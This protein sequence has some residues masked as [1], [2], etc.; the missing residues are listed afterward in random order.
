MFEG[1]KALA[2]L[3]AIREQPLLNE[4]ECGR[5]VDDLFALRARWVQRAA[6]L[7]CYTFGAAAYL[8]ATPS[9]ADYLGAHDRDGP[10]LAERFGWIHERVA[11]TIAAA[12]GK[13]AFLRPAGA[14][15]GFHIF[16]GH[17]AFRCALGKVH[18]DKQHRLLDWTPAEGAQPDAGTLSFTLPIALPATGGGLYFWPDAR[19]DLES[20]AP[21]GPPRLHSYAL[22][23]ITLHRGNVWHQIAP[24]PGM[25]ARDRRITMQGHAM[26]CRDGWSIYW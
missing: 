4:A 24:T 25:S 21:S 3:A 6:S 9:R 23:Q 12:T 26:R 11:R 8:D 13:P 14:W 5:A 22:G 17:P 18:L 15:P 19:A 10:L 16:L 2:P 20:A 7:P 1:A